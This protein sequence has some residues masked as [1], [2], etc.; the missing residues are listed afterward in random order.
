MII[1]VHGTNQL[2]KLVKTQFRSILWETPSI[3]VQIM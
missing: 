2:I 3:Y 1:M